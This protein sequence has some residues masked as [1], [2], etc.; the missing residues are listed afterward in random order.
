MIAPRLVATVGLHG[1]AS[2][3][4]FNIVRE[5]MIE[6]VG[7]DEVLALYGEDV[8]A[9]P[10]PLASD[11]RHVVLKSHSGSPGWEWLV[12]LS[13][14]PVILS[15]RDPRDAVLSLMER[16]GMQLEPSARAIMAD[17]RRAERC[18]E[19]GHTAFRYEDRFFE[20]ETLAG[21]LAAKLGLDVPGPTCREIG[22]RY[23]TEGVRSIASNLAGLPP[24]RVLEAG[25]VQLDQVTQ[26]H[27]SHLGDGRVGK[28]RDRLSPGNGAALT[29]AFAPFLQRF[30]YDPS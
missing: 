10:A 2:T 30:G 14:A 7:V 18:A 12:R 21:Q 11:R 9:L 24:G 19:A 6:A 28:W 25:A 4:L 13:R 22:A 17:C 1:S 3:S 5:L 8:S 15:V 26:I 27:R 20:D 16:F 23:T 29:Q